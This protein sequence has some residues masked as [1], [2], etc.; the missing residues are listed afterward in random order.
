[1]MDWIKDYWHIIS[2]L[3]VQ[4]VTFILIVD[5]IRNRQDVMEKEFS[6]YKKS[7]AEDQSELKT[8]LKELSTGVANLN[9][10]IAELKTLISG[11]VVQ[12]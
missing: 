9:I 5:R 12:L 4:T 1:M 10:T 11:K 8:A 3:L 7:C 2:F 6:E